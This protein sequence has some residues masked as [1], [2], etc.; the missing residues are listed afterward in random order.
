MRVGPSKR[1]TK[2]RNGVQ[3][4]PTLAKPDHYVDHHRRKQHEQ[5]RVMC[6]PEEELPLSAAALDRLA[7]WF[8]RAPGLQQS[9]HLGYH[10]IMGGDDTG[11]NTRYLNVRE[12]ARRLQVHENTI[13]SWARRGILPSSK[14]PGSRF[15]RFEVRDVERL[16]QQRG[17]PVA[18]LETERRTIGPE[19]VDATQLSQWATTREAQARFPELIRRLLAATSGVT[20]VSIRAGEG[21]AAPGWDGR[22][23]SVGS[24]YL[25]VGAL[26]IE[27]GVG[28]RPAQKADD[29]YEK[30]RAN[31]AEAIP[32]EAV[33]TF[34]TPRR[35]HGGSAWADARRAEG[36]FADVRVL[37]ADDLEGWLQ[38][39]PAV[40]YWISE[41]LGRR[42]RDAETLDRWWSRF[43]AQTDPILPYDLFVAGRRDQRKAFE[44]FVAGPA[45]VLSLQADWRDDA[46]AFVAAAI[47]AMSNDGSE[48]VQSPLTVSSAE[49]WDRIVAQPGRMLLLPLIENVDIQTAPARGH[50][51]LI[52][53]GRDQLVRGRT[54][55]LPRLQRPAASEALESAG[56]D[57]DRAYHLAALARRSMPSLVR[58]L[59]RDP[60][61]AKP[62]WSRS[63]EAEILAPLVLVGAW[64]TSEDDL[65]IVQR[66]AEAEWPTVERSLNRWRAGGDRPFVRSG[67]Q[68]HIASRE[69]AHLLLRDSLTTDDLERWMA[70]TQDVLLEN[71]PT[72]TLEP[73]E[74]PMAGIKG[75]VRRYSSTVRRGLADGIAL[76]GSSDDA[77]L[78][79]GMT[80]PEHARLVVRDL[81]RQ[82]NAESSARTWQSLADVLPLLAEGAPDAFVDAVNEDLDRDS[83]K[84]AEMF[85][86]R[87]QSSA[88]FSSSPHTGLLWALETLCWSQDHLFEASYALARLQAVDPGGRLA[89]RPLESLRNVFVGWIRHTVA[90]LDIKMSAVEQICR[91]VP[92]TGW[93]LLIA[94][95]PSSHGTSSP[96]NSPRYRDW[97]PETRGI[98]L[99][100]WVEYIEHLVTLAIDLAADDVK[101]WAQL[102]VHLG[103]LPPHSRNQ[104]LGAVERYATPGR[105]NA[106]Q[107]LL[108]WDAIH[109]EIARHRRFP[110]AEWSMNEEPLARMQ[111]IADSIRPKESSRFAYLFDWRPDLPEVG[112]GDYHA[113]EEKLLERRTRAVR[114]TLNEDSIDG[115]RDLAG[116]SKAPSQLGWAVGVVSPN[117]LTPQLLEWLDEEDSKLR[118]V[119]TSWARRK[120]GTSGV[121]WLREALASP[122]M[123]SQ[124]RRTTLALQAPATSEVW[125]ALAEIDPDLH[126]AYWRAA[127][128]LITEPQ[129][130]EHAVRE[131]V[132]R[133]R[134][135]VAVDVLALDAHRNKTE[136]E[137][138]TSAKPAL[139]ME[140]LNAAKKADPS[141]GP[142]QSPGYEVG[143]LLDY[144][145][146]K[147]CDEETLA[148]YEFAFFL[149][150]EH[151]RQPRALFSALGE[152]PKL[153]VS[154]V[155]RVYRGKNQTKRQLT[156]NEQAL[157]HHAWWVL[158]H[159]REVPGLRDDGSIDGDHLT[160][161][162]QEVRLALAEIDRAD[163]GDEQ[164][165]QVL[166]SSPPGTDGIWPA[167]PVREIVE[168][169]GSTSI[170][171]G[172]HVG[173][174]NSRGVTSRGV[175]DG[176]EQERELAIR[177]RE[178]TT[179]TAGTW[180]RT[181]RVLRQLAESY[182][183]D[184]HREDEWAEL[185]AD[186]E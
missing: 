153:F 133:D 126:D 147:G 180:P 156:E 97:K 90:P 14:V 26:H 129:D 18:T 115:L 76:L 9:Q 48:P 165:G 181:S 91:R 82:A 110:D 163:I 120:L 59:A 169:I 135:W 5:Q 99:G 29:D 171:S 89:N 155:E 33:F 57:S 158:A 47:H 50:H 109:Q 80:G 152:D 182:E 46:V 75:I 103:P 95:W 186:T 56:I 84:L 68:W 88:M 41:H 136:E 149:L 113:Y 34:V 134:A 92:E 8:G 131:L 21:V 121:T 184:A 185:R 23:D 123:H 71:D 54:I 3:I 40:H 160:K 53:V 1:L 101:R 58:T 87:D 177:Y 148:A 73:D 52:P 67:G 10:L 105:L 7:G 102:V 11:P 44:D 150:L 125:E 42:P 122:A 175:F 106:K 117:E 69:E 161:W 36:V 128:P 62:P 30:R 127:Q 145:E 98:A 85:Q 60:R 172:I 27:L 144:L 178:W 141:A 159:W 31:L 37:D 100:D 130:L 140:V 118:E 49:V 116:R 12:T 2:Q 154:L 183:R 65:A 6:S 146:A 19:L 151:H 55:A 139:V 22:A 45:D 51:V 86:D 83:P 143:L 104:V 72:L 78:A 39:T 81:L 63:P 61:L 179:A 20:N 173:V 35:W 166:A 168:T 124:E 16:E 108:L 119:A 28:A 17:A 112:E 176:G 25:P 137:G 66:I 15:H 93:Q 114:E 74:R 24:A 170:E 157:A 38:A 164:I 70:A 43:Q 111:A 132:G 32:Q 167:E 96:P 174:I 4:D 142:S 77:S 94:T 79:D 107:R 64:T 13:R 162:V 138:S